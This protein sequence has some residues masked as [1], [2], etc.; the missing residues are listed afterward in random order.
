M[1]NMHWN[2]DNLALFSKNFKVGYQFTVN[3]GFRYNPILF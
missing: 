2:R 3:G 1:S